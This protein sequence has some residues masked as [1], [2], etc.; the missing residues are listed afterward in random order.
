MAKEVSFALF[1]LIILALGTIVRG[2][3]GGSSHG[4][5]PKV[6]GSGQTEIVLRRRFCDF[7]PILRLNTAARSRLPI[8]YFWAMRGV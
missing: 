1:V 4:A 5:A 8:E 3:S 6:A 2:K 7:L